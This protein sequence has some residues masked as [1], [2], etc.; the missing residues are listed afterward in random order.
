MKFTAD[1]HV[2]TVASGHAYNTI[3]EYAREARSKGLKYIAMTDHGPAMAGG[4]HLYHFQN[5]RC[6][7]EKI[8]GVR[9]L[10]GVEANIMDADGRLDLSDSDLSALDVVIASFHQHLGYDGSDI[11]RNTEALI[12][13]IKN[14]FV[15]ILGHPGNPQFS[16]DKAAVVEECRKNGVFIEINNSSFSGVIRPGSYEH[17]V[18]FARLVK[19]AGW[20]V[21]FGSDSHCLDTLGR[22]DNCMRIAKEAGLSPDDIV[23]TSTKMVHKYILSRKGP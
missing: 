23:N 22:F 11:R 16:T 17:C 12:K 8:S 19:Q 10:K 20:K 4:P 2:H 18:E 3:Y 15:K 6:L 5:L 21:V 7:P 14:P 9:V 1:F 13:A